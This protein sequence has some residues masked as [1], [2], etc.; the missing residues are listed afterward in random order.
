MK[1]SFMRW[2]G[3][4][5]KALT[6]SYDDGVVFDKKLIEIMLKHGI[7]GTFNI[8]SGLFAKETGGRRIT[9]DEAYKL[10]TES[11]MEVAVHGVRHLAL[12]EISEA[13]AINDIINDRRALEN[14]FGTLIEGMAYAYGTYDDSVVESMRKCGIK[15][16]RTTDK[17]EKFDLPTDWLRWNP[18]YH[19]RLP[20][21]M[22]LA[23]EFVEN[24]GGT[25]FW[26]SRPMLFYLWGHSYEFNDSDNWNIIEEFAEYMGGRDDIW[27]ATNGEIYNYVTAFD[28]LRYSADG[29]LVHNPTVIDVYVAYNDREYVI[30]AGKTVSV[31]PAN[32]K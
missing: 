16:A 10:Y 30:P 24:K 2:P 23:G 8:N 13:A 32:C 20:R 31:I 9:S 26:T 29:F 7:K 5:R 18:T 1:R 3:F 12:D 25:S 19:H 6:L 27:Y 21:L 22:E 15:Y 14:M 17:T 4:R 28:S 11:G